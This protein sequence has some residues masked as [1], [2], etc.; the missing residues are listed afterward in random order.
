[1]PGTYNRLD[2]ISYRIMYVSFAVGFILFNF[3][4]TAEMKSGRLHISSVF[5]QTK[6]TLFDNL[7]RR[8]DY[9]FTAH[10]MVL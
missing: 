10:K 1:M 4:I 8:G 9:M 2:G 5:L 3:N 7:F 6:H